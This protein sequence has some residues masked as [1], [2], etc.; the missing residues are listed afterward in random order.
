M[1]TQ[2][3]KTTYVFG[4]NIS[5]IMF[6]TVGPDEEVFSWRTAKPTEQSSGAKLLYN[7]LARLDSL[8]DSSQKYS[9]VDL[10]YD[11][12]NLESITEWSS[13]DT[14]KYYLKKHLCFFDLDCKKQVQRSANQINSDSLPDTNIFT[15]FNMSDDCVYWDETLVSKINEIRSCKPKDDVL[16]FLRSK[17]T[18]DEKPT[19]F[20]S[21]YMTGKDSLAPN[22]ILMLNINDLKSGSFEI[23][24]SISWEQMANE[25]YRCLTKIYNSMDMP[26]K[27]IIVSFNHEGCLIFDGEGS[28]EAVSENIY[29]HCL[30]YYPD[31]MVGDYVKNGKRDVICQITTIMASVIWEIKNYGYSEENLNL[32]VCSGLKLMRYQID[33][34]FSANDT[35]NDKA[36]GY[37]LEEIAKKIYEKIDDKKELCSRIIECPHNSPRLIQ[38]SILNDIVLSNT[39]IDKGETAIDGAFKICKEIV[40]YGSNPVSKKDLC[41]KEIPFLSIGKLI[42]YDKE[43]IEKYREIYN[44]LKLYVNS[45]TNKPLSIGVFG[46]PGSGKS[47]G[48]KQLIKIIDSNSIILEFN[49]SQMRNINELTAAFHQ[50]R[51]ASIKGILPIV[52]WDEFDSS[53]EKDS[54]GWLKYFLA[55]MQDGT[56]LENTIEHTIGRAIFIFAGG[57][58]PDMEHFSCEDNRDKHKERKLGD[59]SSRLRGYINIGSVNPSEKD[60]FQYIFRRAVLIRSI[61]CQK[62][63]ISEDKELKIKANTLQS[64]LKDY[65]Y[66]N[67]ARSIEALLQ[68]IDITPDRIVNNSN[69]PS[70][71]DLTLYIK[72]NN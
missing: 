47:F 62:L 28:N 10:A 45:N 22:T 13:K 53:F 38:D 31:E 9:T 14:K 7:I 55:P 30:L 39:D 70:E 35:E 50:I 68:R 54:L 59:F 36:F 56:F 71:K 67:G 43:E 61:I 18:G 2:N 1:F 6:S 46:S 64:M 48:V 40:Q 16:I 42:V 49:L 25:T 20:A 34:G 60:D 29:K 4:D 17:F 58:Y 63:H 52:F 19:E 41:G 26:Y 8:A 27:K 51:D 32:G 37:P 23:R 69:L 24:E 66:I 65:I 5:D 21:R 44:I 3:R 72:C 33:I 15:V 11:D 12:P 57:I